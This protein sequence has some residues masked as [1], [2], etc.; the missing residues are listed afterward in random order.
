MSYSL[1]L[2]HLIVV[3]PMRIIGTQVPWLDQA[4]SVPVMFASLVANVGLGYI[5]Y[6]FIEMPLLS[7]MRSRFG[8]RKSTAATL[9]SA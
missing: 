6:R 8:T 9:T 4:K 7:L 2:A 3:E 1:Y 5:V